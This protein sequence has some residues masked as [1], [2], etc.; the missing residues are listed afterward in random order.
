[1]K[2]LFSRVRFSIETKSRGVLGRHYPRLEK[3]SEEMKI[4]GR[5]RYGD[6]K[7]H[8]LKLQNWP[9]ALLR[10]HFQI[11]AKSP[12]YRQTPMKGQHLPLS[13][14][15]YCESGRPGLGIELFYAHYGKTPHN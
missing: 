5:K 14:H 4:P 2:A 11:I 10:F 8:F 12:R 1:L 13:W 15:V 9:A 3:A 6:F 7:R